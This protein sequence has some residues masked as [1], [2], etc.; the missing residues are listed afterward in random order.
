MKLNE[1]STT[2]LK[3]G[4]CEII[5]KKPLTEQNDMYD[6][7]LLIEFFGQKQ[8]KKKLLKIYRSKNPLTIEGLL[9]RHKK[10][11]A[12]FMEHINLNGREWY[13]RI[14]N[15]PVS[16]E[17]GLKILDLLAEANRKAVKMIKEKTPVKVM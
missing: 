17:E 11:W 13:A 14:R 15:N 2:V 7:K 10:D 5:F 4:H 9:L 16:V 12:M 6:I 3:Y 1:F 8:H